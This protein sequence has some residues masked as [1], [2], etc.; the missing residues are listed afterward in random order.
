MS[1][2]EPISVQTDQVEPVEALVDPGQVFPIG[3][4]FDLSELLII[5]KV[6]QTDVATSSH[7]VI[8]G[9]RD[10]SKLLVQIVK[11]AAVFFY[12]FVAVI[13][14]SVVNVL[15]DRIKLIIIQTFVRHDLEDR[16]GSGV[17]KDVMACLLLFCRTSIW[18]QLWQQLYFG[19]IPCLAAT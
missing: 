10:F 19:R 12:C 15:L 13:S 3:K 5:A 16:R 9:T 11:D 4:W 17:L 8:V 18:W 14:E 6:F 7:C 1:F 2:H